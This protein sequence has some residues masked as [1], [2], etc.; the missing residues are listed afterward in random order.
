MEGGLDENMSKTLNVSGSLDQTSD[1]DG[2]SISGCSTLPSSQNMS[3]MSKGDGQKTGD[4]SVLGG[5]VSYVGSNDKAVYRQYRIRK[6]RSVLK[7]CIA[8][9][10]AFKDEYVEMSRTFLS[11]PSQMDL[12][13]LE[14]LNI[15]CTQTLN[16]EM[17]DSDKSEDLETQAPK[18]ESLLPLKPK[19]NKNQPVSYP[20]PSYHQS[21]MTGPATIGSQPQTQ[22]MPQYTTLP[23]QVSAT[24][25]TLPTISQLYH[26]PVPALASSP[27]GNQ[28]FGQNF[29]Q[30]AN[31]MPGTFGSYVPK[32]ALTMTPTTTSTPIK[33]L[34]M[35][36]VTI[37]SKILT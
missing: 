32:S 23:S 25:N 6:T 36:Q 17:S 5:A 7:R 33:P 2:F 15:K 13:Q 8:Q 10:I 27:F 28:N 1:T 12:D 14:I 19:G 29:S 21:W 20:N 26:T 18:S 24:P 35:K 22:M 34:G 30:N 16:G 31:I 9:K 3:S 4:K 11:D 37:N